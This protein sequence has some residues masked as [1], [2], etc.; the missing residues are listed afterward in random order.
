ML[1]SQQAMPRQ[2]VSST[3][4]TGQGFG[5]WRGILAALRL[6]Y[7]IVTPATWTRGMLKGAPGEGKERAI[8]VAV[9]ETDPVRSLGKNR[10]CAV[11]AYS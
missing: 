11:G 6:P 7:E 4:S 5:M 3:F 10:K 8:A 1:E 9:D 2:G